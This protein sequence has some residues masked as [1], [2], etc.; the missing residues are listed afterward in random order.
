MIIGEPAERRG[1]PQFVK[2]A[3]AI[4]RLDRW[5]SC[6]LLLANYDSTAVVNSTVTS[7]FNSHESRYPERRK[8]LGTFSVYMRGDAACVG[9]ELKQP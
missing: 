1:W 3:V 4:G 9:T 5:P 8:N 2:L 7:S 6:A